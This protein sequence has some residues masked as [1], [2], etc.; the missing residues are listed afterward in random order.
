MLRCCKVA[1]TGTISSGKSSVC[2][3]LKDLGA[4]GVDADSIVHRLLSPGTAVGKRVL[5]LLGSDVL[6]DGRFDRAKIAAKVFDNSALL[7]A[8]ESILHPAVQQVIAD[9]YMRINTENQAPLFVA[10]IPLLFESG[11]QDFYDWVVVVTSDISSCQKRF[12]QKTHYGEDEYNRRAARL[13]PL[14]EKEQRADFVIH[15]VGSLDDLLH[16]VQGIYPKLLKPK[17]FG[18]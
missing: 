11:S 4:Y 16:A 1:V 18:A 3:F 15:N 10:E 13:I 9:E 5:S 2:R 14:E 7:S 8:L 12:I 17:S 6:N